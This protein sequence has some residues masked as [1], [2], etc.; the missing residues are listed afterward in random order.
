M[1]KKN[2]LLIGAGKI[3]SEKLEKFL[4]FTTSITILASNF[5]NYIIEKAKEYDLHTIYKEYEVDDIK[6]FDIV[7]VA[8]D[9]KSLQ[10]DIYIECKNK[11]ILCN[12]V[13]LQEYCDFIFPSYIKEGDLTVVI[14]TSGSSPA[15]AKRF[16]EYIKDK[17][18]KDIKEFLEQM[19]GLRQTLPKG[20]ERMKFLDKKV[21]EYIKSWS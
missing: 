13:D 18:P 6:G 16:K 14:S 7:V 19:R 20:K 2:V 9:D 21:K 17:L 5:D 1:D 15:F 12:C 8:I 10:K 11:N 4:D 3:A